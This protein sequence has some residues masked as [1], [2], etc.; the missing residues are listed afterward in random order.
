MWSSEDECVWPATL[1]DW[2]LHGELGRRRVRRG[3]LYVCNGK[4]KRKII[5]QNKDNSPSYWP[6]WFYLLCKIQLELALTF[7]EKN[8]HKVKCKSLC[9][10]YFNYWLKSFQQ[11]CEIVKDGFTYKCSISGF[12]KK[13]HRLLRGR[14]CWKCYRLLDIKLLTTVLLLLLCQSW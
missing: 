7:K 12:L 8:C 14:T 6:K 2:Q 11:H 1:T 3:G 4:I 9:F 10:C 5:W 13:L